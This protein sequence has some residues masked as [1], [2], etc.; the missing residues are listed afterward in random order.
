MPLDYRDGDSEG[1]DDIFDDPF[2]LPLTP[3]D[4]DED[5][6]EEEEEEE[7]EDDDAYYDEIDSFKSENNSHNAHHARHA[8][9]AHQYSHKQK[10]HKYE[11]DIYRPN[12]QDNEDLE[13]NTRKTALEMEN[14]SRS[15]IDGYQN[16]SA[17]ASRLKPNVPTYIDYI[18]QEDSTPLVATPDVP[19]DGKN[20]I[21]IH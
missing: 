15:A 13:F 14:R 12:I 8:T 16:V 18:E 10:Q 3:L 19:Y 4:E 11:S 1:N 2:D 6:E 9:H 20:N 21:S 7:D 5:D 17:A